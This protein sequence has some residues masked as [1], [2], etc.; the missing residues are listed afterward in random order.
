MTVE[1]EGMPDAKGMLMDFKELKRVLT[2]LVN[3]W[4]HAIL[5]SRDD[6]ELRGIIAQTNWKHYVLPFDSTAENLATYVAD[7]LAQQLIELEAA[8][9]LTGLSIQLSETETCYA[10]TARALP[11]TQ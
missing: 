1:L 4:D 3:A 5:V 9:P 7:F 2:P 10:E 11:S 6:D 8:Q